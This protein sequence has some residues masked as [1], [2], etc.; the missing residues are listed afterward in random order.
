L[1]LLQKGLRAQ[2]ERWQ[3]AMDAGFVYYWWVQ[4]YKAAAE[5]FDSASRVPGAPWWLRSLAATTVAEGGDRRSSRRMW[6]QALDT[7]D[8]DWLRKTATLRVAQIDALDGIDALAA[9]VGRYVAA[10]SR[11]PESWTVLVGAGVLRGV[12]LDPSGTPFVLDPA[13]PGGVTISPTSPLSPLP[14]QFTKKA[15]PPQ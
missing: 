10:T 2:P 9:A 8:N 4:D 11:F 3:Y 1:A 12:P 5:W 14:P 6:Q 13:V 15:S 7:A